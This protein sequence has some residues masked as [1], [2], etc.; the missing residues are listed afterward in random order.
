MTHRIE[1]GLDSV[2]LGYLA[3]A[4]GIAGPWTPWFAWRPVPTREGLCW[5]RVVERRWHPPA[6]ASV[7]NRW[8]YRRVE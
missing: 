2:D 3:T 7:L 4:L 5:L 8:E 1:A 6:P